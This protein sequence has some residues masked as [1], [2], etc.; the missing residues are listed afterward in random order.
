[1]NLRKKLLPVLIVGSCIS[2]ASAASSSDFIQ[3]HLFPGSIYFNNQPANKQNGAF[4]ILNY[5]GSVY[6]PL[7]YIAENMGGRVHYDEAKKG[8]YIDRYVNNLTK[9]KISVSKQA[10]NFVLNLH[11]EKETYKSNEII[12]LWSSLVYLGEEEITVGHGNPIILFTVRDEKGVSSDEIIETVLIRD[13]LKKNNEYKATLPLYIIES[14]NYNKKGRPN[15][16]EFFE[17]EQPWLLSPGKYTI[18]VT[19]DFKIDGDKKNKIMKSEI[20]IQVEP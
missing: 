9:A 3:A 17:K 15:T 20:T 11:S 18:G 8:I 7:R 14:Y 16:K 12:N 5:N 10:D 6:V 1:M 2:A 13:Q 19:A 4:E